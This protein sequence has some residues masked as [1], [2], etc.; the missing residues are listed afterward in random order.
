MRRLAKNVTYQG[1]LRCVSSLKCGYLCLC[2]KICTSN[3]QTNC[4]LQCKVI[5]ITGAVVAAR[6]KRVKEAKFH[7][8]L[9]FFHVPFYHVFIVTRKSNFWASLIDAA[10]LFI[11]LSYG[12]S[13]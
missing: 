9:G 2:G 8:L 5:D 7:G 1:N 4:S 6:R 3:S 13:N 11:Y 10:F 12:M